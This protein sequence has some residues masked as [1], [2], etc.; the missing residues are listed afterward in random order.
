M[1]IICWSSD[2]CSSDLGEFHDLVAEILGV[3]DAG[4]LFGLGQFLV[5]DLPVQKLAGVRILEIQILD[6]RI[7]IGDIEV[8]QVLAVIMIGFQR[9][10]ARRVGKEYV[11]PCRSRWS[12]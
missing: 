1:R 9:S 8:E 10:E 7:G 6:P 12:R 3:G 4:W 11:S 5:D 2:V